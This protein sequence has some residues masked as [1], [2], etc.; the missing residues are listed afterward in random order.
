MT[1]LTNV[2]KELEHDS[3][4]SARNAANEDAASSGGR[5]FPCVVFRQGGRVSIATAF[6]LSFVEKHII[7]DSAIKGGDPRPSTNRPMM[8]DHVKVIRDYLRQNR[9]AYILPP[10]TLNVRTMPQ[11]HVNK[12]NAAVRSGFL[13]IPDET[14]FYITD[15]QHRIAAIRGHDTGKNIIP[16]ILRDDPEMGADGL[17]V[18]IVVESALPRIH[19]DFAD[20]AHTKPIPPSLLAAYNMREPINK[21]LHIIVNESDLLRGRVDE[22]SKTLGK[23]S[24]SLFLL[25][26]VRG[27]MKELLVG[28]FA[29][30][31]DAFILAASPRLATSEQQDTFVTQTLQLL[32]VLEAQMAPWDKIKELPKEGGVANQIPDL[33]DKY[34]NL[35]A[36][37]LAVI[38]RVAFNIN[39]GELEVDRIKAYSDLATK[40][41]W[42]RSADIWKGNVITADGKMVTSRGPVKSAA[43]E[44]I[45][46]LAS[47]P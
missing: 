41:N 14:V 33:R 20:A 46:L 21:V 43:L 17:C 5:V 9:D 24:Q 44:V 16:G 40:V 1:T 42:L 25:N 27:L 12:S 34:L 30:A 36:T 38:G 32:N 18:M 35:K 23:L 29:I 31:E 45:K 7:P 3:V 4:E 13:V 8:P 47:K 11:V 26:Q 10:V 2:T 6:P 39:K 28:D 19:Q 22:T 37:G 15:G